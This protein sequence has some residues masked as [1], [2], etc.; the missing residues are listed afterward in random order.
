MA[1]ISNLP[2]LCSQPCT[3]HTSRLRGVWQVLI[4]VLCILT[5]S[6]ACESGN[7]LALLK[8]QIRDE[9]GQPSRNATVIVANTHVR[10]D[11]FGRYEISVSVG[12]DMVAV[13]VEGI[14]RFRMTLDING[15]RNFD[16]DLSGNQTVTV[17]AQLDALTPDP[18]T[19]AFAHGELL[20]A[21][22]GRPGVPISVPGYPAETAS[23]GIK[24][25]QYFA[26][27][28]AG[29]H[30]EPIA[31]YVGI[32][33]FLL[34]NNLTANAH[35]NGYADP[36][37]LISGI[38]G[39][40][41]VD[42]GAFNARY[43]DHA[44]NLAL[45]YDLGSGLP[46]TLEASTNGKDVAV[47]GTW[48]LGSSSWIAGQVLLGNGWLKRPEERQQYK[49]NALHGWSA[50]RHDFLFFAAGYYGFSRIPGLIPLDVDVPAGT[51]D[52]RQ[53]DLTH[54]SMAATV[55]RWQVTPRRTLTTGAFFRTY[56]L[57]LRSNFGDGLIRQSEFRTIVGGT[58]TYSDDLNKNWAVF[59]SLEAR[60]EAPRGLELEHFEETT[61]RFIPVSDNDLTIYTI[62]PVVA[63]TGM[64]VP[65]VHLYAGIRRDQLC[66]ENR[67]LLKASNSFKACP[68]VT[69][70]KVNLTFGSLEHKL[71]P[72]LGLSFADAFHANDPRIG[73]GQERGQLISTAREYQLVATKAIAGTELRLT[74]GQVATSSEFAKIDADTGLQENVGPGLNR[75]LTLQL[76]QR[77]A[78]RF[79][80]M[81]WSEADARDRQDRT[82]IPEAPR[83]IVDAVYETSRLPFGLTGKT[84]F[85]Y[86]KAK[87]LGDGFKDI[88]LREVRFELSKNL[89][90]DRWTVSANGQWM[91]GFSGQTLETISVDSSHAATEQ[92]VGIP[93]V[94][95]ATL[96]VRYNFRK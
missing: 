40:V 78:H 16:I 58:T 19:Q 46:S 96:A 87:P 30:G 36:N 1:G 27:G 23:G 7:A 26:P 68:G 35:G 75:F 39:G 92:P 69:S 5:R 24:A 49:L 57:N 10:T 2:R 86:V 77:T 71:L 32:N 91:N 15:D 67:D 34:P 95:Y 4:L 8:G 83:M 20:D 38:I 66:V 17:T 11:K 13:E 51:V 60:R 82:P 55:D 88:P 93:V 47:G 9:T 53:A 14:S 28:V 41:I 25:P 56:S 81:S 63:L 48:H 89:Q 37:F 84:E 76:K 65:G 72:Q 74:L 50:G 29:D 3:C 22:P 62:A 12:Q 64:V 59:A 79:W 61:Q 52:E 31:Q 70:P 21:N 42:N 73:T 90:G 54:T 94:S 18:A 33:S 45:T 44:V 80:Q 6:A 85:E 43:G